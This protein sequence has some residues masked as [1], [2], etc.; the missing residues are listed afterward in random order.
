MPIQSVKILIST[1]GVL[2]TKFSSGDAALVDILN[3]KIYIQGLNGELVDFS[4]TSAVENPLASALA[5]GNYKITGLGTPTAGTDAV[6]KAY[7]DALITGLVTNPLGSELAAGGYKI[8]GLGTPTASTDAVTKAYAD[9]LIGGSGITQSA[10]VALS[11]GAGFTGTP[12]S[13]LQNTDR[14]ILAGRL[15]FNSFGSS[16][17]CATLTAAHRPTSNYRVFSVVYVNA[18]FTDSYTVSLR[19]DTLGNVTQIAGAAITDP[20]Y[21]YFDGASFQRNEP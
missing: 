2:P 3:G 18:A 17:T 10:F 11:N 6:T 8:T 20:G 16:A 9:S 19:A 14:V 15:S 13:A 7:A 1:D 12:K 4:P 5:A 21:I